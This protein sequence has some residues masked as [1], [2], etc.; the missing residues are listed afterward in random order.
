MAYMNQEKKK[1]LAPAIK[2]VLKK[3]G[4]KGTIGVRHHSSLVVNIKSGDLDLIGSAQRY[5]DYRAQMRGETPYQVG[6]YLQVNQFHAANWSREIGDEEIANFYDEL[7]DAMNGRGASVQNHN[8]SDIMTDYF[9]VG[10]YLD[11][12]VGDWDKPYVC[13]NEEMLEAA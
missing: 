12:N 13:N 9:D 8:N 1:V 2:A 7:V 11:I 10:W 6:K 3:Y 4:M 5:N